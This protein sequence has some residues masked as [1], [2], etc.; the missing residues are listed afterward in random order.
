MKMHFYFEDWERIY[1]LRKVYPFHRKGL[2]W[3]RAFPADWADWEL[4][5]ADR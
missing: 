3:K 4:E 5:C 1:K 2:R